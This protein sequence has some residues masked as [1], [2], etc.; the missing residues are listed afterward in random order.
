VTPGSELA[1]YVIGAGGVGRELYS[2]VADLQRSG[3]PGKLRGFLDDGLAPGRYGRLDVLGP[4]DR[5][6]DLRGHYIIAI[7]ANAVRKKI[8]TRIA[9]QF[10]DAL[11]AWSL[12]HPRSYVGQDVKIGEGCQVHP[13]A[14][15]SSTIAVGRHCIINKNAS[16]P[17]DC[18]IADF[19]NI[20]DGAV[21]CGAVRVGEGAFV[22]AGAVLR[23]HVSIGAWSV[24][25]AGA[26]VVRDVP[27]ETTV[28]GVPARPLRQG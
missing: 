27:P 20:C 22:G 19:A 26:V 7:G 8:A 9:T 23:D 14:I 25:G 16:I 13:G 24:V 11:R 3:W 2:Y 5:A 18:S 10:G 28:V 21:L 17:H 15:L 4:L 12:I 6:A 1:L